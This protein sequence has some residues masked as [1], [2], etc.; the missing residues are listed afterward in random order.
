MKDIRRIFEYHGAEH[1]AIFAFEDEKELTLENMQTYSTLHPRCGTSFLILVGL[2]CVFLFTIIDALYITYVGP[3]P[4]VLAR[5]FTHLLLV[6]LVSGI[7]YEALKLSD[8]YQHIPLVRI[9][10]KPGLWL[11]NITTRQPDAQQLEVASLALRA[12]L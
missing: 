5:V 3:Y 7:S 1:K 6:P 11:Q 4:N 10:I 9:L 12:A 2:V 8:R